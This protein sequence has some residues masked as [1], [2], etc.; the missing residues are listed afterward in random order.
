M[1][2]FSNGAEGADYRHNYCNHC[3]HD[4]DHGCALYLAH[5]MH[6]GDKVLNVLIPQKDGVNGDCQMF[7][8]RR[9]QAEI[10]EARGVKFPVEPIIQ[11]PLDVGLFAE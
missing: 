10:Y 4:I 9:G 2:Y 5:L 1:A 11:Q 6:N 7:V 3:L 8:P